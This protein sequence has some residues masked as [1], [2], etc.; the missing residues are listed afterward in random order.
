[1]LDHASIH[2]APAVCLRLQVISHPISAM[3]LLVRPKKIVP[4]QGLL[5]ALPTRAGAPSL[6]KQNTA[7]GIHVFRNDSDAD[8]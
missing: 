8:P 4:A 3:R 5:Y 6:V 1:M 7:K 2:V